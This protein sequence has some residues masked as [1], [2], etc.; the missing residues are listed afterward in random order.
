[1]CLLDL[2]MHEVYYLYCTVS[3]IPRCINIYGFTFL[4]I[5]QLGNMNHFNV[6]TTLLLIN[7]I[8]PLI[9]FMHVPYNIWF[10]K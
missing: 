8:G 10:Q 6:M 3:G 7:K 4:G 5:Y 2:I 9:I 1:M